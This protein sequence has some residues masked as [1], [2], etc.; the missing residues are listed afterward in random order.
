MSPTCPPSPPKM[1]P[2][3]F[4]RGIQDDLKTAQESPWR[5]QDRRKKASSWPERVSGGD[6]NGL[7]GRLDV[8]RQPQHGSERPPELMGLSWKH[9]WLSWAAV[10]RFGSLFEPSWWR[11]GLSWS[12]LGASGTSLGASRGILKLPGASPAR[13]RKHP[14]RIFVWDPPLEDL[15]GRL[16]HIQGRRGRWESESGGYA[17]V[18]CFRTEWGAFLFL[19]AAWGLPGVLRGVREAGSWGRFGAS[20]WP[21]GGLFGASWAPLGGLLEPPGAPGTESSRCPLQY[22]VWLPSWSRPGGLV[23]CLGSPLGCL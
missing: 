21:L 12:L 15:W 14:F 18:Y 1:V 16:G 3:W 22:P 13:E 7:K 2:G 10:G 23:G 20:W 17:K 9:L 5:A 11:R 4:P 19:G 8:P 6:Q